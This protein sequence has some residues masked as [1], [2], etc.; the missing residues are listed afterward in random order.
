MLCYL[1]ACIVSDKKPEEKKKKKRN[2]HSSFCV[3]IHIMFFLWLVWNFFL[4]ITDFSNLII[5]W[6]GFLYFFILLAFVVLFW[7]FCISWVSRFIVFIKSVTFSAIITSNIFLN[8][9]LPST[10]SLLLEQSNYTY[11]RLFDCTG[12][13]FSVFS[14]YA[15]FWIIPIVI[16]LCSL[17]ISSAVYNMLKKC[18]IFHL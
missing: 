15:S 10:F 17:I 16:S 1:L 5:T 7:V 3:F 8:I 13:F 12:H 18:Y 6:F 14:L 9:P 2:L 11:T 4:F